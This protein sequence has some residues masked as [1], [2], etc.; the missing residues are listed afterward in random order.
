MLGRFTVFLHL[1]RYASV[2]PA[3][4]NVMKMLVRLVFLAALLASC[5]TDAGTLRAAPS[6]ASPTSLPAVMSGM[7]TV[8][9]CT[10]GGVALAM[11][12]AVPTTRASAAAPVALY[13]HGGG[14]EHGDRKSGGFLD[15]L[16]PQ[17]LRA[18]FVVASIDYRLAPRYPWPAQI[19][20]SKCAVRFLRAHALT[21]GI[22]PERIGVWGGSAGG[23]LVSM[24]GTADVS[25][26][27]DVGEW[28]DESSR[29]QA[30][31]DLFGPTDLTATGWERDPTEVI[32]DVFGV[33]AGTSSDVLTRASP[34]TYVSRDDPPFL[35]LQGDADHTVPASQSQ[36]FA[37]RSKA[38]GVDVQLVMVHDG[39]HGLADPKEQPSPDAIV[40]MIVGFLTRTLT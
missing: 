8:T 3:V 7:R 16:R 19:I 10:D 38:A 26:G 12:V 5:R 1:S 23:H 27:F 13:V 2:A 28:L 37:A 15:Q 34:V 17:L 31:V 9:Y 30:V 22:D 21:Y 20:D 36:E 18:G 6:G 29:V 11:D 25:A 39:P 14:W 4:S 40:A 33:A 35:V 24:L 32:H